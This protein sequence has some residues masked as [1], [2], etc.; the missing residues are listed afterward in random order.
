MGAVTAVSR[1]A[2]HGFSKA[3]CDVVRLVAGMGVEG[4]AHAGRTVQ[5]LSRVARDP[6]APNLRQVHLVQRELH[7]ELRARG[8]DVAPGELGENVTTRD[9]D[10]L[11]LPTGARLALGGEAVVEVTGLRNPCRQLDRFRPGLMAAVLDRDAEGGLVRK[12]GVMAV[13]LAGGDV[14]PGD[15]VAVALPPGP[16][17]PLRPV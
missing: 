4:D 6:G 1:A 9:V 8:F 10:L 16:H 5:H 12:A 13:V 17:R 11:G 2:G 14:R 3:T 15:D 7:E